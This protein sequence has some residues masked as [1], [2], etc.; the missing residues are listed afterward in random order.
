MTPQ[1]GRDGERP[2]GSMKIPAPESE[3]YSGEADYS[4]RRQ[5]SRMENVLRYLM[6]TFIAVLVMAG[7][8]VY[9]WATN[10]AALRDHER[11]LAVIEAT[12]VSKD[13]AEARQGSR[14]EELKALGEQVVLLRAQ[15]Q[16]IEDK[17]D[18]TH[19]R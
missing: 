3:N 19:A 11:R 1:R 9:N 2:S 13:L 7:G 17:L 12:Y 15:V 8:W 6:P 14:D 4:D 16:R 5:P 10:A 18:E